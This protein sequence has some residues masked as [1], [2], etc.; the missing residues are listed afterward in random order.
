MRWTKEEEQL[1]DK[2]IDEYK[3]LEELPLVHLASRLNRT[4]DAIRRKAIRLVDAYNDS[5]QW[6]S[7]ER[8]IAFELYVVGESYA[9]IQE[10]LPEVSMENIETELKRLRKIYEVQIKTYA[11]ERGL[12]T[13]KNISLAQINL[14]IKTKDTTSEFIRK[15]LHSRIKNG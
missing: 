7:K 3:S 13:T 9:R 12:K 4:E 2:Y 11:E 15:G 5:H 10:S 1:L 8:R 14:F 6:T